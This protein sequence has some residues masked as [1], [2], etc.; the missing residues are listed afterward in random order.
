MCNDGESIFYMVNHSEN[1]FTDSNSNKFVEIFMLRFIISVVLYFKGGT[2][3]LS[4]IDIDKSI[5]HD[6]YVS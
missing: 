4:Q 1:I 2:L 3:V 6:V 5:K